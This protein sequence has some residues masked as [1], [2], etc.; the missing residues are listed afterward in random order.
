[1]IIFICTNIHEEFIV[2]LKQNILCEKSVISQSNLLKKLITLF[3]DR[4]LGPSFISSN[5]LERRLVDR[6]GKKVGFY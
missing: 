1:M 6:S 4:A 3:E 5:E 2:K